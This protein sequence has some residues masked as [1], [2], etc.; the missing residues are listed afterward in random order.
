LGEERFA[1]VGFLKRAHR[2]FTSCVV[3][4]DE[5][6]MVEILIGFCY[7]RARQS[8]PMMRANGIAILEMKFKWG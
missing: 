4:F 3:V 6:V 7:S 8:L 1:Q 2:V 5:R